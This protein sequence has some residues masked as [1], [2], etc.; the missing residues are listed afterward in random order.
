MKK[1]YYIYPAIFNYENDGISISF[2]D[3][4]GCLSCADTDEEALYM[5]KDALGL[6]MVCAEEDGEILKSPSKLNEI[7]LKKSERAILVEVYMP[8]F[9]ESVQNS[10]VKKTLT[11]PKWINDLAEK[12]KINFSQVLQSALKN[13]LGI[14]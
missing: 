10:S 12:N 2:P 3:L 9:R 6:Y 8:L 14:K 4:P 13:A 5:A 7:S 1:D 11:I